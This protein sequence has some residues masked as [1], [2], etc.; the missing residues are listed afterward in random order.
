MKTEMRAQT[1]ARADPGRVLRA[2][3]LPRTRTSTD[4]LLCPDK[5]LIN[6]PTSQRKLPTEGNRILVAQGRIKCG[7][8]S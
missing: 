1:L 7:F 2:A 5:Q 8:H 4:D 3:R 6:V